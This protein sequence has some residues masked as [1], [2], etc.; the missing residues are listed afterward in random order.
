MGKC[1]N[2]GMKLGEV[3]LDKSGRVVFPKAARE[4]AKLLPGDSLVIS[5]EGN[6]LV[7]ELLVDKRALRKD[8]S[9]LVFD[10]GSSFDGSGLVE[11]ERSDRL[12]SLLALEKK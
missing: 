9:V 6:R 8:G 3:T 10:G 5:L 7:L 4:A 2:Y 12:S 1:H 11:G